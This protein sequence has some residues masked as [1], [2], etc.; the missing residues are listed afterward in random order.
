MLTTGLSAVVLVLSGF[1]ADAIEF[2]I[3]WATLAAAGGALVFFG[4]KAAAS[5]TL[6]LMRHRVLSGV[7]LA[8]PVIEH[9]PPML[10]IITRFK[11]CLRRPCAAPAWRPEGRKTDVQSLPPDDADLAAVEATAAPAE[12][13]EQADDAIQTAS[14]FID[15]AVGTL[16]L[17]DGNSAAVEALDKLICWVGGGRF[18]EPLHKP[19]NA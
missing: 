16:V 1:Q 19:G 7:Y 13:I 8:V 6:Q 11:N 3:A 15:V 17:A 18:A 2:N 4:G 12:A 10:A 5:E 9:Q 14:G